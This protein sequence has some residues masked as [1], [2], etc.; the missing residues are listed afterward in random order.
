MAVPLPLFTAV[1]A[2]GTLLFITQ[3]Q[4]WTRNLAIGAFAAVFGI[5]MAIYS[6]YSLFIYPFFLS[7]YRHLPKPPGGDYL[8]GHTRQMVKE[9]LGTTARKW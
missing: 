2:A 7:P 9:G 3:Q 6:I 5:Q 4:E 8:F 1:A